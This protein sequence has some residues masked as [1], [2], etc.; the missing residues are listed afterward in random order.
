MAR[1]CKT[2]D[3]AWRK[4]YIQATFWRVIVIESYTYCALFL[5][6][7]RYAVYRRLIRKAIVV[8]LFVT[9]FNN[10]VVT[11]LRSNLYW[12]VK[13]SFRKFESSSCSSF[14]LLE[15]WFSRDYI[16]LTKMSFVASNAIWIPSEHRY[17]RNKW[18]YN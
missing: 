4:R 7:E 10:T 3:I 12:F 9:Q 17:F 8:S 5:D 15:W 18:L 13:V 14:T 1:K 16:S 11:L 2:L 6:S